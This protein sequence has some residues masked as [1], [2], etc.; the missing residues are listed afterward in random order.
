[1]QAA[2][3]QNELVYSL[4]SPQFLSLE[5]KLLEYYND[6][7]LNK[8]VKPNYLSTR[9]I[10]NKFN[11]ND[12]SSFK[13]FLNEYDMTY[14]TRTDKTIIVKGTLDP[15]FRQY[16]MY[17]T[18]FLCQRGSGLKPVY[19]L[20]GK[21]AE[22]IFMLFVNNILNYLKSPNRLDFSKKS[23]TSGGDLGSDFKLNDLRFDVK[24]RDDRPGSGLILREN[25]LEKPDTEDDIIIVLATNVNKAKLG[26]L[27]I[28]DNDFEKSVMEQS[29]PI[30]LTGWI[31]IGEFK[32]KMQQRGGYSGNDTAFV[33]DELNDMV[34]LFK[35]IIERQ[36]ISE[37]LFAAHDKI[38]IKF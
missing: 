11:K 30:A 26:D 14:T 12:D 2:I 29:L 33:V 23:F 10:L 27:G 17:I 6:F 35:L 18:K 24:Y 34:S 22:G 20:Q 25:F 21:N 15:V 7:Y 38:L 37:G 8:R 13:T 32:K 28:N 36:S 5:E 1:M 3:K 19:T 9:Q 31:T 4:T 16:I